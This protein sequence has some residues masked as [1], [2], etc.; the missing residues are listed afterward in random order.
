MVVTRKVGSSCNE[1]EKLRGKRSYTLGGQK[2]N[3]Y[4]RSIFIPQE[5]QHHS[6]PNGSSA[7]SKTG[8]PPPLP[9][10]AL[11]CSAGRLLSNKKT[12]YT[13]VV[14][15]KTAKKNKCWSPCHT[16]VSVQCTLSRNEQPT[17]GQKSISV[18]VVFT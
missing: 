13:L 2:K 6:R 16:G 5:V 9:T 1:R 15:R 12:R 14:I 4:Y 10:A 17:L 18:C 7:V 8:F 11:S 3:A